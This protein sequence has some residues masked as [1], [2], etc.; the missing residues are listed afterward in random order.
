MGSIKQEVAKTKGVP[1]RSV[2]GPSCTGGSLCV[3]AYLRRR[4]IICLDE[5]CHWIKENNL[6]LHPQKSRH[7]V[8]NCENKLYYIRTS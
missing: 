7:M 4:A 1:Q 5:I 2:L 3:Q 6:E 8:Q